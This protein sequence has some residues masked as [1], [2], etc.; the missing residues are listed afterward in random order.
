MR[1][2]RSAAL[3]LALGV[4]ACGPSAPTF[5]D[6]DVAAIKQLNADFVTH[7]LAGHWD[8]QLSLVAENASYLPPNEP[9]VTGRA[10]MKA[11]L[12]TFP[13]VNSFTVNVVDVAG[14]GDV[15]YA[16]GTYAMN[17]TPPGGAA[18]DDHGKWLETLRKQADGKWLLV[19]D[20]WNSDLAPMPAAAPTKAA[21]SKAAPAKAAP[22]KTPAKAPAKKGR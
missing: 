3:L 1:S 15:A 2:T 10:A 6:A 21:P 20:S 11:F 12:Q 19:Y 22:A 16:R 8:Q 9:I 13:K 7:T 17:A 18:M 14:N 4:A 5:G